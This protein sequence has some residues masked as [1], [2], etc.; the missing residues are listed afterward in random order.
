M[1]KLADMIPKIKRLA[2]TYDDFIKAKVDLYN[3][4]PGKLTGYD[5]KKCLNRGYIAVIRD[6]AEVMVKCECMKKRESINRLKCSGIA[7][8][9]KKKTFASYKTSELFQKQIKEHASEFVRSY[10]GRWFFIGGQ[11]GCG[12]THICTAIAGQLIKIGLSVRYML[13]VEESP[14]IKSMVN[15]PEY[16]EIIS[17]LQK[18]EV[19]YIDDLF[20]E[21]ATDADIRLAFQILDY[22]Y[23]NS[24]CTFI[25]SEQT[26]DEIYHIDKAIGGRIAEMSVKIN[27]PKDDNKD[28][29]L[30]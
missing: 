30:K 18:P 7:S 1:E 8:Q 29:R 15:E 3:S 4:V 22:R 25:S 24:M 9:I 6:N 14:V 16:K 2:L 11:N 5:C 12:K 28:F 13:W 10:K 17:G 21:G 27:I 20:K 26:L 19:L 23:R